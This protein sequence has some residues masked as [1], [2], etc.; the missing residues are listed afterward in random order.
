MVWHFLTELNILL[1][2]DPAIVLLVFIYP[3]ELKMYVHTNI[4][5]QIF[6]AAFLVNA[7]T[8][9][10]PRCPSVGERIYKLWYLQTM[11][12]SSELKRKELSSH[13]K[14]WR[15]F[16]CIVLSERNQCEK[17]TYCTTFWKRQNY[18]DGKKGQWLPRVGGE[19]WLGS[20]QRILGSE[21]TLYKIIMFDACH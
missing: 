8:W 1:P 18:E 3:M 21:N 19:G 17:A 4:C 14:T 7:K 16:K 20:A 6:R 5:T 13:E 2:Y 11:R 9:M 10:Q 15:N 12:Y